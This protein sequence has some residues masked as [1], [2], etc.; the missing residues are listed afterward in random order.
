VSAPVRGDIVVIGYVLKMYPRFSETFV[1]NEIL[2]LERRGLQVRIFSLVKPDDGRF[3]ARLAKV[4]AHVTYLPEYP[5]HQLLQ[6][7]PSCR[8]LIR[9]DARRFLKNLVYALSHPKGMGLKHFLKACVLAD[10]LLAKP[11]D[12]LHAHFASGATSVAMLA[13]LF[14]GIPYSL[15]AHAKDIYLDAVDRNLLHDKLSLARFVVTV[16]DFNRR[17]LDD[18]ASG[19]RRSSTLKRLRRTDLPISYA[20]SIRRLYNGIDLDQFSPRVTPYD[21]REGPPLILSVGRLVEKKGFED[22]VRACALLR[23]QGLRFGC[24]IIGKGDRRAAIQ[25]L[26]DS[27]GLSGMVRLIGP[28]PLEEMTSSYQ[29]AAV[30]ALP[31]LVA[32][33]GNRDG[34]PTVL[35]EAMAAGIPVVSTHLTGIPELV[36]DGSTGLLVPERDPHALAAALRRLLGDA[37][38]REEMGRRARLKVVRDFDLKRNVA[39]LHQWFAG[40]EVQEDATEPQM[41]SNVLAMTY[42]EDSVSVR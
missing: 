33:D 32:A 26:A 15:T 38:L 39:V 36:D 20:P 22:L 35:V 23:D 28:R 29:R 14:T 41:L 11:V 19:D 30:V 27:L 5:Q 16:S 40:F 21:G 10:M 8:R 6:V 2:E 24:E 37:R 9:R 12:Q 18:L 34:I 4:Q 25:E 1:L 17:F 3:H 7:W 31:C 42:H 13:H